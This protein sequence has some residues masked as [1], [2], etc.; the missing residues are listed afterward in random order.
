MTVNIWAKPASLSSNMDLISRDNTTS[1]RSYNIGI[2]ST[3]SI[4]SEIFTTSSI[5]SGIVNV[6]GATGVIEINKWYM[7]TFTFDGT[8][9][10]LYLN[11]KLYGN[12]LCSAIYPQTVETYI[13]KRR[14]TD[15]AV[16]FNGQM[17]EIIIENRAWSENEVRKYYTNYL[18]R[19]A[20]L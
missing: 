9:A 3:G 12:S 18:G 14:I 8:T 5:S 1:K 16:V 17:D 11:G 15:N 2:K 4:F 7:I 13:G 20:I 19:F 6:T 10:K